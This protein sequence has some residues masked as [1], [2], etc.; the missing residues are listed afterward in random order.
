MM[1]ICRKYKFFEKKKPKL[2]KTIYQYFLFLE[3]SFE[4]RKLRHFDILFGYS[5]I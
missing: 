1:K 3:K 2:T 4:Y 5:Q